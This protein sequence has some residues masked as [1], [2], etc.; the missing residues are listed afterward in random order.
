MKKKLLLKV[1]TY[2]FHIEHIFI[3]NSEEEQ[4][5]QY[6]ATN[7]GNVSSNDRGERRDKDVHVIGCRLVGS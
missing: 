6:R 7:E 5:G 1:A 3:P 2:M 4:N